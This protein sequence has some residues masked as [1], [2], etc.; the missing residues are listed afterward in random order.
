[1]SL[2]YLGL[3]YFAIN[4]YYEFRSI[5]WSMKPL[6]PSRYKENGVVEVAESYVVPSMVA[7]AMFMNMD[8]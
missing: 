8:E 1:M 4:L 7:G 6:G 3:F 2:L 5:D